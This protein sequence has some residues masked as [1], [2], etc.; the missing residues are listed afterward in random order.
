MIFVGAFV[1]NDRIVLSISDAFYK[2]YGVSL[3]FSHRQDSK[4]PTERTVIRYRKY[5]F[6]QCGITKDNALCKFII[7]RLL[8]H[9]NHCSRIDL[10]S[11]LSSEG[12]LRDVLGSDDGDSA[13]S[14]D[15]F[16]RHAMIYIGTPAILNSRF[17]LQRNTPSDLTLAH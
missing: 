15:R 10:V 16:R 5:S 17:I 9:I 4:E 11:L 8:S 6:E 3:T 14:P 7:H 12:L 1:L 13:F 2:F